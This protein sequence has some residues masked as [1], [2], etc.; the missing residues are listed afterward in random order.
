M[1]LRNIHAA[2]GVEKQVR[3]GAGTCFEAR[4][5]GD[6][7][8]QSRMMGIGRT[9]IHPGA[10]IGDHQHGNEEEI[11]LVLRGSGMAT[12]DGRTVRVGPGDVMVNHPHGTHG[13]QND[14]A[15]DLEIFA[16]A[17]RGEDEK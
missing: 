7:E 14:T 8:L 9:V 17:V 16:F 2:D 4:V 15:E 10:S 5:F 11:Y 6:D 13:L 3:D 1:P 12:I